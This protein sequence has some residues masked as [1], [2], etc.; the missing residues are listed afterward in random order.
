MVNQY[1][2]YWINLDPTVGSEMKKV[3][4]CIIIS[5]N[6]MNNWLNT[7][8]IAPLTSTI[9]QYPF[10]MPYTIDK[11]KGSICLD[12]IRSVDKSRLFKKSGKLSHSEVVE[13]K[14]ILQKM[15]ID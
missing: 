5:P 8:L 11:K 9:K 12:Q 14:V 6:E 7:V 10:R 13:L 1:E 15:L 4:P 3:R 2:V